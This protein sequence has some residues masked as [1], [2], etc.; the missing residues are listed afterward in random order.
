MG[1]ESLFVA[2]VDGSDQIYRFDGI[3]TIEKA[4]ATAREAFLEA[5]WTMTEIKIL[6]GFE[7][8]KENQT[9]VVRI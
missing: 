1:Q 3:R 7:A 8:R 2:V 9:V 5:G 4:L 6:Y